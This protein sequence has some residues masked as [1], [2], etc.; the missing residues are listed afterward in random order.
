[1]SA[2]RAAG[3]ALGCCCV[4]R[5]ALAAANTAEADHKPRFPCGRV[6]KR[7][8]HFSG[9]PCKVVGSAV[10]RKSCWYVGDYR[11]RHVAATCC[12]QRLWALHLCSACCSWPQLLYILTS[13][14]LSSLNINTIVE[15]HSGA[16]CRCY[17]PP[18]CSAA[19][20]VYVYVY[21][22]V[23]VQRPGDDPVWRKFLKHHL[24]HRDPE[25]A[26]QAA[27]ALAE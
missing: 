20:V 10:A 21:V 9:T 11:P 2:Y 14:Q 12:L 13:Q 19:T 16:C 4:S 25:V 23:S 7:Q 18:L 1:V 5:Q 15:V 26:Q 3:A 17:V 22:C 24:N 27:A 8:F 6:C